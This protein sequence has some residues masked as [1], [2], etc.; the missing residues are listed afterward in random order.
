VVEPKLPAQDL[1][2]LL[3]LVRDFIIGIGYEVINF[4]SWFYGVGLYQMCSH[5]ARATLVDHPLRYFGPNHFIHFENHNEGSGYRVHLGTRNGWIMF[6][7]VPMD[8]RNDGC[9]RE[10]VNTFGDF[11]Y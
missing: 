8:F 4:Q 9:I 10:A 6:I 3:H 2:D 11:H 7:G 5:V 1:H